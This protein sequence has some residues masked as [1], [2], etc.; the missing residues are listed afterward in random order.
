MAGLNED[1]AY[2]RSIERLYNSWNRRGMELISALLEDEV[3]KADIAIIRMLG[4]DKVVS[5]AM[6]L[7]HKHQIPT[8]CFEV[9]AHYIDTGELNH[10]RMRSPV[11]V[12]NT[13]TN[14]A[15]PS[16]EINNG[17]K[18]KDRID[19]EMFDNPHVY[20]VLEPECTR[21]DMEEF[22]RDYWSVLIQP[23]LDDF[24]PIKYQRIKPRTYTKRDQKIAKK[25]TDGMSALEAI[26]DQGD[27]SPEYARVIKHRESKKRRP[28]T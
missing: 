1:L 3:I 15:F 9:L 12:V 10:F 22:V 21:T 7:L 4:K 2:K 5:G 18:L 11:V 17:K 26:K 20:M 19:K 16:L 6:A 24:K 8:L 28:K 23:Q 14:T 13:G 27:I 25:I